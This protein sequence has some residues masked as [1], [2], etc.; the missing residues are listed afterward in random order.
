[1]KELENG[2]RVKFTLEANMSLG[3]MITLAKHLDKNSGTWVFAVEINGKDD[4]IRK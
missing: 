1:M 4:V 3:E 2:L